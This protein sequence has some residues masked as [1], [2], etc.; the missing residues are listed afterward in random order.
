MQQKVSANKKMFS[1]C[2]EIEKKIFIG[3]DIEAIMI[4]N[5]NPTGSFN[6]YNQSTI[7]T[8]NNL[9][10]PNTRKYDYGNMSKNL[11]NITSESDN[12]GKINFVQN[13]AEQYN[14]PTL[15]DSSHMSVDQ[16]NVILK[17]F[18]VPFKLTKE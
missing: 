11:N 7:D 6:D 1:C 9:D 8:C 3:L 17:A 13:R 2:F 10:K 14:T 5:E 15:T 16:V 4:A 12:E 18:G